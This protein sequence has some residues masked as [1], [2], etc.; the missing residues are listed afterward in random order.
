MRPVRWE[1]RVE[2]VVADHPR[3]AEFLLDRGLRLLRC[4]EPAW[5][6]LGELADGA[7]IQR[8]TLLEE[9]NRFLAA[10]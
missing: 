5:C 7:G 4:G 10:G 6:S 9:L 1:D 3:A 2:D 8:G